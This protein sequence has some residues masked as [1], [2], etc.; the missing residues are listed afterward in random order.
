MKEKISPIAWAKQKDAKVMQKVIDDHYVLL[1][2]MA[3]NYVSSNVTKEDLIAQGTLGLIIAFNKF[4]ENRNIKFSTY[5]YYW[6]KNKMLSFANKQHKLVSY[7][8]DNNILFD[9]FRFANKH[10]NTKQAGHESS[11]VMSGMMLELQVYF[12]EIFINMIPDIQRQVMRLRYQKKTLE[13]TGVIL[14]ISRERVRQLE[15]KTITEFQDYIK[16]VL[17]IDNIEACVNLLIICKSLYE[18]NII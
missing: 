7:D 6:I 5:A 11:V 2:S 13:E 12:F 16:N 18:F 15:K 10:I 17:K 14:G 4:D 9:R 3:K 8:D 1:C